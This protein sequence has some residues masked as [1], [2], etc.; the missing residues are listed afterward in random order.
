MASS[1]QNKLE[2]SISCIIC[3][4]LF[5]DPRLAPC[6]HT[7]CRKCIEQMASANRNQFQCPL[8]DGCKV[9]K[10]DINSLPLNRAVRDLVELFGKYIVLSSKV[11]KSYCSVFQDRGNRIV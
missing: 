1:N 10:T 9:L 8:R 2:D 3:H 5:D 4:D 6:S 7:Y 11:S